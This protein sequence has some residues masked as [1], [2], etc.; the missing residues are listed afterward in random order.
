MYYD[1]THNSLSTVL[2]N[3]SS[4]F[5]ETA[6]KAWS[7]YRSLPSNRKPQPKLV[8]KTLRDLTEM[9]FV[10]I[11]SEGRNRTGETKEGDEGYGN[12]IS[13]AQLERLALEAFREALGRRQSA[14]REVLGWVNQRL[15]DCRRK[16]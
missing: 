14:F 3:L 11:K 13:K 10:L 6:L 1:T 2:S 16:L 8:I 4:A 9:A 15:E 7:Y 5:T 12:R